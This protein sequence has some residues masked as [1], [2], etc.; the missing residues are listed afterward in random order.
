MKSDVICR[1]IKQH[2]HSFLGTPNRLILIIDLNTLFLPFNLKDKELCCAISY[3]FSICQEIIIS[4]S[5]QK[6]YSNHSIQK[7]YKV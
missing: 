6:L 2:T 4:Y 3:F 5:Y 1:A 7:T